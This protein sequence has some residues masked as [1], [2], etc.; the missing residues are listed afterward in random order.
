MPG[1]DEA[2]DLDQDI[3][4]L[5]LGDRISYVRWHTATPAT[6]LMSIAAELAARAESLN[7]DERRAFADLVVSL[8]ATDFVPVALAAIAD[9][10]D[11]PWNRAM[12]AELVRVQG[13]PDVVDAFVRGELPLLPDL[14]EPLQRRWLHLAARRGRKILAPVAARLDG[15]PVLDGT[16]VE[17]DLATPLSGRRR[18][19]FARIIATQDRMDDARARTCVDVLADRMEDGAG[20]RSQCVPWYAFDTFAVEH[21]RSV[22]DRAL[23]ASDGGSGF[24]AIR[25][26]DGEAQVLAGVMA[27][28]TGVLGVGPD[29]EWNELDDDEYARLRSRIADA[30][31]AAD[32]VGIPD[33]VQCLTG[34]HSYSDVP[35]LCHEIGVPERAIVPGGCDLGWALE[36]SGQVDR[37]LARC[38]GIIGP[39]DPRSLQRVPRDRDVAWLAV[40]GELLY[41]YDD[42]GLETSHWSRFELIAGHDFRPGE[43]WLVGA[44]VLGKVYCQAIKAAGGVA[45]DVG[46]VL[47]VWSG[48]QDTRGTVREQLW[49]ATPYL[50][51]V[52]W[53]GRVFDLET[54]KPR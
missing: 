47:D 32:F 12:L 42:S 17:A 33:L 44:G 3:V 23:A 40:P 25:L 18:A 19:E 28:V 7:G 27:D 49:V 30:I 14:T 8:R 9:E 31:V 51:G 15:L 11:N 29:G 36:I 41:Y 39:I 6:G 53:S 24:S 10:A 35:V 38:T 26:G 22:V 21:V 52:G 46:S 37:L 16:V 54:E 50:G 13:R 48:R 1:G 20:F 34:P 45:I 4:S 5:P 43:V 2:G